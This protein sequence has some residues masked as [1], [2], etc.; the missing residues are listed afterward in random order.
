[1][2]MNRAFPDLNYVYITQHNDDDSFY[3]AMTSDLKT[4]PHPVFRSPMR[5]RE[6][7]PEID[8]YC[9]S[10]PRS[11]AVIWKDASLRGYYNALS[12]IDGNCR[13]PAPDGEVGISVFL[14]G[15]LLINHSTIYGA[16]IEQT[17]DL[18]TGEILTRLHIEVDTKRY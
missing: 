7:I 2:L 16:V 4:Y 12:E 18:L 11:N 17:P 13:G 8:L 14:T 15:E 3:I 10:S 5:M 1:M 6:D 9:K